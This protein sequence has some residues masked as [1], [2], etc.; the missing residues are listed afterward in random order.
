MFMKFPSKAEVEMIRKSYPSG[1]KIV[2]EYMD[3]PYNPVASGTVGTVVMV[4]SIGQ[5]HCE[6]FG[7]ALIPGRDRFHKIE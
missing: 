7:L 6:E 3:D 2:V 5:V 4:D 1:T